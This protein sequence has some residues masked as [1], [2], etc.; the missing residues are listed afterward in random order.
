MKESREK[1]QELVDK[2]IDDLASG[3]LDMKAY[4]DKQIEQ[5]EKM[6]TSFS[7][8]ERVRREKYARVWKKQMSDRLYEASKENPNVG[9]FAPSCY[10]HTK[11]D[12]I[13]IN[14]IEAREALSHWLFEGEKTVIVDSCDD[15]FCNPTCKDSAPNLQST[16]EVDAAFT[17]NVVETSKA[18]SK[19]TY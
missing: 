6:W 16:K 5:S 2:T 10:V 3:K 11:F 7:K 14:D 9:V 19:A 13:K 15:V 4:E 8:D 18:F 17:A 1:M 12:K